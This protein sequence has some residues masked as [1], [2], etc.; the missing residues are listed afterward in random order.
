MLNNKISKAV[1]LAIA[2]GAVSTAAF[3]ANTFAADENTAEEVERIEVTGS[4]IKR[5]DMEGSLPVQVINAAEIAKTG[6]TTVT[7]LIQQL[8]AMQGFTT[9]ADSV[10]GTGGGIS[11]ASIH[12]I[13]A[14]YTLVLLNGRRVAPAT[15]GGT[16]DLNII[17]VA[18]IK[19]VEVLTDGAS[20]LYGSDAIAGVLNFILKDDIDTTTLSVRYDRPQEDGGSNLTFSVS[21]GFGDIDT[22][23]YSIALSYSHEDQEQLKAKQRAFGQTGILSF[24]HPDFDDN[25]Y[26][27]NGSPN[28]IPANSRVRYT[29]DDAVADDKGVIPT[30]QVTFNPYRNRTGSCAEDTSALDQ[31]CWFDYTSTIELVPE[32][33]RDSLFLN[34]K[35]QV[36]EDITAFTTAMMTNTVMTARIAPYPTGYFNL[37][38]TSDLVKEQVMPYLP[39]GMSAT[40]IASI[41]RVQARW[42]GLPAGNRTSEYDTTA[43]HI[44]AGLQG[45]SGDI[46]WEGALTYSVND[47]D[48]NYPT[49]W[50]L[51][52]E[53]VDVIGTGDINVFLP[54]AELDDASRQALAPTVYSG[55]WS[56][57]KI[58]MTGAD[59]KASMPVFEMSGGD[60]YIATGFDFRDYK[61]ENSLSDANE[62]AKLLFLTAGTAYDLSRSQ[63]GV[64]AEL[65]MPVIDD[66]TVNVAT[67]Y[68]NIDGVEASQVGNYTGEVGSISKGDSDVTYKLSARYQATEDL[69][70]RGSYGTGFKAP[71]LLAI[72][73]PQV[74]FGVTSGNYTCPFAG[75]SDPLAPYCFSGRAQYG[76][77]LKG[78][79]NLNFETSEQSTIGFVYAPSTNFGITLDYWQVEMEDLITSLS[80]D[81]IFADAT[82]YRELFS[83]R[84]N[85]ATGDQ[86]IA[87][88]QSAVNVGKAKYSGVDWSVNLLNEL[89]FGELKTTWSG[90]YMMDSTYTRP[91]TNNDWVSSL[92]R[93]GDNQSV[94][95]RLAQQV[96]STLTHGDFAHTVRWSYKSG[97]QDQFQSADDCAVTLVD[98]LGDCVS[99]QLRVPSTSLVDYQTV[100]SLNDQ[101]TIT[102]GMNNLFDK[103]PPMSLRTGGA[104]HQVG[105]D[106]RYAD[107]YGR[108]FYL[109]A[110]Y[111]F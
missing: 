20:A 28:A 87:I 43:T 81:Q 13:G 50:L 30:T 54:N 95:F 53:F 76:V 6:V 48:T 79:T 5:T 78:N 98:A 69:L 1:R 15:S 18:A 102:F 9:S 2:F 100:Y 4:A 41:D 82:R 80:E 40:E 24:E 25:L 91:G 60:A 88:T 57:Q 55:N 90:T 44:V 93:F 72:A 68:D 38:M 34:A 62:N 21:T 58:T 85:A 107:V 12:D 45:L 63:Y 77:Y 17:P 47:Q 46:D 97:Y 74:D 51:L 8:P 110:D 39:E 70:V 32:N 36:A 104:G 16:V 42:R 10:G 101:T 7:D 37:D 99:V 106:P 94:T 92:G 23:G 11:T 105:F 103:Q 52:K 14:S 108:T 73:R 86:E 66:L 64:F 59:F 26:F 89:S 109:Q 56:N 19:R 29:A 67:R 22:D 84:V 27:F 3:S 35:F 61:Y 33:Q 49:G 65:D 83:T 75:T 111:S 71:S 96:S 31:E